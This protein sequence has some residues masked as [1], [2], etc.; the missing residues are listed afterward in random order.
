MA[1][2]AAEDFSTVWNNLRAVA[3]NTSNRFPYDPVMV[4][5]TFA[6]HPDDPT[7]ISADPFQVALAVAEHLIAVPL[8]YASIPDRSGTPFAGDIARNPIPAYLASEPR[9]VQDLAKIMLGGAPWY[10]WASIPDPAPGTT[11]MGTTKTTLLRNY[12]SVLATEIPEFLL[13]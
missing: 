8:V 2:Y 9:Y 7:R 13:F 11:V 4:A 3:L 5:R 10:E 1:W 6:P 12:I